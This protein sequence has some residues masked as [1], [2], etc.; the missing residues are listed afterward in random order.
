MIH[1]KKC[2]MQYPK[3]MKELLLKKV[4]NLKKIRLPRRRRELAGVAAGP[5]AVRRGRRALWR[6]KGGKADETRR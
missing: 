1:I 6:R 3:K 2:G 4:V 5:L